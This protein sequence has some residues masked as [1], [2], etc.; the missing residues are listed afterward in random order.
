MPQHTNYFIS[1]VWKDA[2]GSITHVF[3]HGKLESG[4]TAGIKTTEANV[5]TLLKQEQVIKTIRWNYQFR[6][7][8]VGAV[9]EVIREGKK[10]YVRTVKD[11]AVSDTLDNMI[12][13]NGF[14]KES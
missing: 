9:V 12:V 10:A 2:E 7:W 5:I 14:F 4:F 13:M 3:L 6:Q 8:N 1:G 11:T